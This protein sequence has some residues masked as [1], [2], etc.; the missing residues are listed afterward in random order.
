MTTDSIS[1]PTPSKTRRAYRPYNMTA[2]QMLGWMLGRTVQTNSG[3][4]TTQCWEWQG[5]L[6]SKGYACANWKGINVVAHRL[7]WAISNEV[8][9]DSIP[10]KTAILHMCRNRA[11]IRPAHLKSGRQKYND[12]AALAAN[13]RRVADGTHN[14]LGSRHPLAK[15]TEDDIP[16]IRARL[17]K[18][19]CQKDI[20][21]DFGVSAPAI[22]GVKTGRTWRHIG[23]AQ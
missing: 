4:T 13:K 15:L 6:T 18:G 22:S 1:H 9:Y 23:D 2:R 12:K 20:A 5:A 19:D 10:I 16:I 3:L 11:C 21:R 17:A 7:V 8:P 14:L